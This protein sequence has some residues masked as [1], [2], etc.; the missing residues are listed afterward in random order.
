M[1]L[2]AERAVMETAKVFAAVMVVFLLVENN[3]AGVSLIMNGSFESDGVINDITEKA[4]RRWCDVNLPSGQFSA[5]VKKDWSTHPYDDGSSLT[6][7]WYDNTSEANDIATVSQQVYLEDVNKII[8]DIKLDTDWPDDV[9]WDP[10]KFSAL[11]LID[12]NTVWDS[13]DCVPDERGECLNVEVGI[14][15]NDSNLHTLSLGMRA[16]IVGGSPLFVYYHARWDFVKFDTHCGGFGYL[17][18]D[19]NLDCYVDIFDLKLLAGQWLA[20]ELNLEYDLFPDEELIINLPDFATFASYWQDQ[21]CPQS[22]WCDGGD[23]DRSGAVDFADLMILADHWLGQVIYLL[24]DFSGDKVVNFADFAFL[25]NGWRDNTDW[26]NWQE[27]NCYE[28]ELLA[29]DIDDSGEVYYGDILMVADNWLSEGKC[30]RSDINK[31]D[32]VNFLDFAIIA[33]EWLLKSWLYGLE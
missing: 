3:Q 6:L 1:Y 10:D 27:D 29:G 7:C 9:E 25:A 28:M 18:E 15:I 11:L 12:G 26:R 33:D 22:N 17:P 20:E 2:R 5:W 19:L 32:V 16:A 23:F 31:D 14:D 13:D 24:S 30:I 4:P 21:N 8:F